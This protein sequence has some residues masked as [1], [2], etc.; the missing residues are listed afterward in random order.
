MNL[1]KVIFRNRRYR[2]LSIAQSETRFVV[3]VLAPVLDVQQIEQDGNALLDVEP[4][5]GNTYSYNDGFYLVVAEGIF[6]KT[7]DPSWWVAGSTITFFVNADSIGD[8]LVYFVPLD[9]VLDQFKESE[10]KYHLRRGHVVLA[11]IHCKNSEESIL[12]ADKQISV[13]TGGFLIT[14]IPQDQNVTDVTGVF[15][16]QW[17]FNYSLELPKSIKPNGIAEV[18]LRV[19]LNGDTHV[20]GYFKLEELS[21]YLPKKW[22]KVVDGSAT[23]PVVAA[24]LTNQDT[25]CLSAGSVF[26]P[27]HIIGEIKVIE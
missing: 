25:V 22:V 3:R 6:D 15:N 2:Y 4:I 20:T 21:G 16:F 7:A 17:G 8:E 27:H 14:N 23:F 10:G 5:V 19:D 9:G 12:D 13:D 26:N 24:F 11:T 1:R 18:T